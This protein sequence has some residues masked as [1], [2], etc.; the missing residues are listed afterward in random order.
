[1]TCLSDKNSWE[2]I[3]V[4]VQ[5]RSLSNTPLNVKSAKVLR[6]EIQKCLTLASNERILLNRLDE[7]NKLLKLRPSSVI[8]K[9]GYFEIM[10]GG[11]N[12]NR[13]FGIPHFKL[14]NGYWFDFA[15]TVDETCKLAQIIAFDF[16]IRFPQNEGETKVP[17]LR[18]DLNRP[19]HNNDARNLRFHLHPSNEDIMIHSPPMS[20]LEILHMFLYGMKPRNENKPRSF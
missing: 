13:E 8:L 19:D 2:N 6:A 4:D 16:E 12:Q 3:C 17:F 10:G 18:I 5:D 14:D 9:K 7:I 1:M 20:P 11:K 15:I